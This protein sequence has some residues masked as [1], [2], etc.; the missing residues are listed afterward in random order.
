MK[1]SKRE[2]D[3][4]ITSMYARCSTLERLELWDDLENLDTTGCPWMVG[5]DFNVILKEDEKLGGLDFT[6]Q[7][8][9]DFAQCMNS[10]ALNKIL[11]T[12][13]KYTWW[14]ERINDECIFKRLDRVFVN[15]DLL[16]I[17]NLVEVEHFIRKG[18]DHF[19]LHVTC[20][21]EVRSV[22]K[23]FRFLNFW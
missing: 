11:F 22:V 19:S 17:F 12:G 9:M 18:L 20:N 7:K 10:C 3:F 1:F 14:N 8:A 21:S 6:Q 2:K 15:Q 13:S 5:G 23:P 16:D 4:M